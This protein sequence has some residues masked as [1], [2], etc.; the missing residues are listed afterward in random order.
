LPFGTVRKPTARLTFTPSTKNMED[1]IKDISDEVED[2]T[3]SV[4]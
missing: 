4:N 3:N 2:H 1:I